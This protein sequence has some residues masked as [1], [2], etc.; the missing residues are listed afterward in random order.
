MLPTTRTEYPID[1]F[2]AA[3]PGKDLAILH[4]QTGDKK[5][6]SLHLAE[7]VPEQG[8]AVYVFGSSVGLSGTISHG[9]VM[10]IRSGQELADLFD[11]KDEW[12]RLLQSR[13]G[14][15]YGRDVGSALRPDVARRHRRT[16]GQ[17]AGR[18]LGS[19]RF[20]STRPTTARA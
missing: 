8:E 12:Q 14:L 18:F 19:M 3:L 15:R 7:K 2:I 1:G 17:R 6:K 13:V 9:V 11:R 20:V 4:I 5:L 10:A 16:A